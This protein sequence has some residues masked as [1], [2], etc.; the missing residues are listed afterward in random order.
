MKRG[1]SPLQPRGGLRSLAVLLVAFSLIP[2]LT[3]AAT[4]QTP[5]AAPYAPPADTSVASEDEVRL[6][7]E[8]VRALRQEL[9]EMKHLVAGTK[10][11]DLPTGALA[12]PGAPAAHAAP[13][14]EGAPQTTSAPSDDRI[15]L[16]AKSQGGDLAGAGN[17]LRSDRITIG[18]YG[19]FQFRGSGVNEKGDGGGTPTFNSPR[20]VLGIGAVLA[21]K[22]NIYFS[23]EIEYEFGGK[24]VE[25]EQAFV[26]WRG[27]P[28]LAVRGGIF[29]PS[30]GRFNV[31]HDS[32]I[33]IGAIRPLI[34]QFIVPTAYSDTGIGVRG[35]FRL[36][37]RMK[38]SYEADLVNGLG[39]ASDSEEGEAALFSRLGGQAESG[40]DLA[41]QDVNGNKA[42]VGRLGFSPTPGLELGGSIY[43]GRTSPSGDVRRT[44]RMVFVDGS[45]SRGGLSINGEYARTTARGPDVTRSSPVPAFDPN[46]EES[47]EALAD[48]VN[49][50][51]PGEDGFYLEGTYR[52][53]PRVFREHFDDG[54]YIAPIVRVEGLRH[55]SNNWQL[56]L[57]SNTDNS[58]TQLRPVLDSD[59]QG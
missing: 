11:P 21:E 36:P 49:A 25:V 41:F 10:D 46:D 39:G 24:E 51:S 31:Y 3:S 30:I 1:G 19:D 9:D 16:S 8:E 48:F 18:G 6:L 54:A 14:T 56:L 43:A 59:I 22:Q 17:L 13:E 27:R 42:F 50:P 55:G 28:E 20:L 47:L 7:R 32:N 2:A 5:S 12:E 52:F 37:A 34:N 58:G 4:A 26:E 44:L 35:R 53:V 38:L 15:A 57:E 33:N 40:H 29:T 45:Y 23:S